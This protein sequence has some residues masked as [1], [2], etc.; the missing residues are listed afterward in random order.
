MPYFL[1][2][3]RAKCLRLGGGQDSDLSPQASEEVRWPQIVAE[4]A[5]KRESMRKLATGASRPGKSQVMRQCGVDEAIVAHRQDDIVQLANG[6]RA[7]GGR[8]CDACT[9]I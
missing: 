8:P 1:S 2:A 9:A 3:D 6:L 5:R 7:S 4:V